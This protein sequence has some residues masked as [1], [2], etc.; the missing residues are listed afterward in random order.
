MRRLTVLSP[1]QPLFD[2]AQT[3]RIEAAASATL[4]PHAL[5][6]RA[7]SAVARLALALAPHARVVRVLAGTGNNGGDGL[8]AAIH[9]MHAGKSVEVVLLAE[10]SADDARDALAR[11]R[12][13]G[14]SIVPTPTMPLNAADLALDALLGI[15][16]SRPVE[17]ALREAIRNLRG[18]PCPVLS[19]DLPSGLDAHSGQAL[20]DCV[21]AQHTLSLLTLK[22]G[23][24]TGAGR[25]HAGSVWFDGLGVDLQFETPDA[26]LGGADAASAPARRHAQ[27]KGS[28]GDVAVVGGARGLAGAALLA[29][30]AALAAGAGRVYVELLDP[31]AATLD[32]ARPE[33]MLRRGW[34]SQVDT[35]MLERS[36]VV[37][38]CGGG[39][40]VRPLLPRLLSAAGRLVLD[41][42]AL[43]A[44]A[45][46]DSLHRLLRSRRGRATVLTP[47]PL[48]AAR[49]LGRTAAEVQSDRLGAARELANA[50]A[51]VVVLKGSGTVIAAPGS[52]AHI[53]S[54]GNAA[55]ATAGTGDVLAG[56][57]GGDWSQRDE[58]DPADRARHA[59]IHSTWRHGLAAERAGL[60]VLRAAD[61]I[62][63]MALP[64]EH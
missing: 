50:F 6:Q 48:E 8:D 53:N 58:S 23:L 62:E 28:F 56:W 25:D 39:D 36:T 55:L 5:M 1:D 60:P 17:G 51:A 52:A 11:A 49:L 32:P 10:P 24:F 30:R 18:L 41:A 21:Q 4:P 27:H 43:N 54:S 63:R 2:V 37:C 3:R 26:R 7:G 34:S 9:L 22:P 57:I 64:P 59:A 38:G 33:L 19:I 35:T 13:A 12:D 46:D 16:A 29:A 42:D 45:A 31:D 40:A 44:I 14:V 20:G 47:H 15:G 61:L